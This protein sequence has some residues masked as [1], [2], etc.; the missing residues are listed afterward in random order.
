MA[1]DS[2]RVY[3]S[4][5]GAMASYAP[6]A[7]QKRI[8]EQVYVSAIAVF[9]V[10][11]DAIALE[12]CPR[13]AMDGSYVIGMD[14]RFHPMQ[15][16]CGEGSLEELPD[17]NA[18]DPLVPVC[19]FANDN[20]NFALVVLVVNVFDGAVSNELVINQNTKQTVCLSREVVAVPFANVLKRG[21]P[22]P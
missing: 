5:R 9:G 3:F 7:I 11:Q 4:L 8:D 18:A 10:S 22:V 6:L 16:Q 12:T 13:K 17:H 19:L 20:T 14:E 2:P 15:V 1:R 21:I